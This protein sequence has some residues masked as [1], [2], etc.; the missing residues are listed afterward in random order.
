MSGALPRLRI[1]LS[2][3]HLTGNEPEAIAEAVKSNW[4]AAVG[5][6]VDAF[7]VEFRSAVVA[8]AALATTSGT[9]ALHLA[10]RVLG[11][12]PG[13]EVL[14]S[15]LTF[16]AS[17]NP[18]IYQGAR[19]VF[20]DSEAR[21][22][23]MDAAILAEELDRRARAGKLP[24]AVVVVHLYGQL[25][26]MHGIMAACARWD[27][28]VV[29]DAAEAIGAYLVAPGALAANAGTIGAMGIFSFDG[30]KMITTSVGGMLVSDA[31]D[32]VEHA[33]NLARQARQP[34][35]HYEHTEI[36]YNYR[37]SNL[38]AAFGRVQLRTLAERVAARRA[39]YDR[40]ALRL[41]ALPGLALQPEADWGFHARW[42]T[43]LLLDPSSG[44]DRESLRLR[45]RER[46]VESRA[47]WKPMHLQ[48]VYI[49][50]GY[51]SLGGKV[52]ADLFERGLCLPSSSSLTMAEVDEV[53]DVIVEFMRDDG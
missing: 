37:M 12:G 29:E 6:E 32:L 1:P 17:V 49:D 45:L 23:N 50:A 52:A 25:A 19:P 4:I 26:D 24:A 40:Y 16:C 13:D 11:I 14:V 33:R 7:E 22:W 15:T 36:G 34:V 9:V 5:P 48:P 20:V 47:V 18:I 2:V 8:D 39:V 35:A 44:R 10:L 30:S 28:P 41:G 3:P 42:L 46:G 53:S 21:S 27:V 51:A 31:V 43:C 38:L